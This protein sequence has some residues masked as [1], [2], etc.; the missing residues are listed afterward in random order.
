MP[1]EMCA[2]SHCKRN[3]GGY[4]YTFAAT[5]HFYLSLIHYNKNYA[6]IPVANSSP[7]RYSPPSAASI[8]LL[9]VQHCMRLEGV[10]VSLRNRYLS[11]LCVLARSAR[12]PFFLLLHHLCEAQ[13]MQQQA[14]FFARRSR[15]SSCAQKAESMFHSHCARPLSFPVRSRAWRS[16]AF[17]CCCIT[18]ARHR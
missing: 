14:L 10:Y 6:I 7:F 16:L 5:S 11:F 17:S 9:W 15:T 4:R 8:F 12:V 13:V 2:T 3:M 18:C 1:L